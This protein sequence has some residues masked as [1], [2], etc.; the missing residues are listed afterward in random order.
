MHF[1]RGINAKLVIFSIYLQSLICLPTLIIYEA[2]TTLPP[3]NAVQNIGASLLVISMASIVIRLIVE[4]YN[5]HRNKYS[6]LQSKRVIRSISTVSLVLIIATIVGLISIS[7]S[8]WS[9]MLIFYLIY[10]IYEIV[11]LYKT[12]LIPG[13]FVRQS[14]NSNAF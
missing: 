2:Y 4:L 14:R 5:V 8:W 1:F 6:F 11:G 9:I 7:H 13:G 12:H 3:H 10:A